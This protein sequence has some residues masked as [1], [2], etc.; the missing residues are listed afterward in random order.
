MFGIL[1]KIFG[2]PEDPTVCAMAYARGRSY[3]LGEF[4]KV[5]YNDDAE[6]GPVVDRLQAECCGSFNTTGKEHAFDR[7]IQ[8]VLDEYYT[9]QGMP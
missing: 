9:E 8:A 3:A 6:L 1:K 2:D 7:G 4:L 5:D